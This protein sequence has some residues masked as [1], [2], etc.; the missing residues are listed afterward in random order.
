MGAAAS[1]LNNDEA[2]SLSADQ[3]LK[4]FRQLVSVTLFFVDN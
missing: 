4:I 2:A 3:Q 1:S